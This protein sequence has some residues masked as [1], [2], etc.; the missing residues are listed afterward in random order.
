MT[1]STII[2]TCFQGSNLSNVRE[3]GCYVDDDRSDSYLY[4][5]VTVGG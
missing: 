3:T 2:V 1:L 5:K 4:R